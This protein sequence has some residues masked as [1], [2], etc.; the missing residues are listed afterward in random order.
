MV[1]E[2][3]EVNRLKIEGVGKRIKKIRI[4]EIVEEGVEEIEMN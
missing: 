1:I 4:I 3:E 2:N